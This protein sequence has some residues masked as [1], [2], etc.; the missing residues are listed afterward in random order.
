[1]H[2][3]LSDKMLVV[4]M[5]LLKQIGRERMKYTIKKVNEG[6]DELTLKY[7]NVTPEVERVLKFMNGEQ[8]RLVGVSNDVKAIIEPNEILYVE[9]VEGKLFVYTEKDVLRLDYTLS[10]MTEML[11]G[12]NFFRCSKSMIINIDKVKY[13]KS[14]PSNRIDATMCNGEHVM[15]NRTFASDFRKRLKGEDTDE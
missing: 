15:I 6:E 9:S 2:R 12:I 3:E 11:S 1:M 7:Q 5:K 10:Q 4:T 13:L 8:M 14:L